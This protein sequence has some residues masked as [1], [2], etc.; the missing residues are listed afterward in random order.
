[1]AGQKLKTRKS[2]AKRIRITGTGKV[3]H[4]KG[5]RSHKRSIKA[6]RTLRLLGDLHE[7]TPTL[8]RQVRRMAP[9]KKR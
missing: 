8:S 3:L 5:S 6:K 9:Y 7:Y 1:M 2:I 4:V